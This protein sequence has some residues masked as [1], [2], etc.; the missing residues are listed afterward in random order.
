MK[1]RT[2][3]DLI[4]WRVRT[5]ANEESYKNKQLLYSGEVDRL[6]KTNA[7]KVRSRMVLNGLMK[8]GEWE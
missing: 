6:R 4:M 7:G 8:V 1:E 3:A 2:K 5:K